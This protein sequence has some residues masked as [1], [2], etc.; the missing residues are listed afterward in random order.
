MHGWCQPFSL[1]IVCQGYRTLLI[2]ISMKLDCQVGSKVTW[3]KIAVRSNT[4]DKGC[5]FETDN[6]NVSLLSNQ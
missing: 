5:H 3:T 2:M 6:Y 1:S 4:V